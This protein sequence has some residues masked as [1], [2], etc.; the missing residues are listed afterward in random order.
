MKRF[1]GDSLGS[2]PGMVSTALRPK[3]T[4]TCKERAS[5]TANSGQTPQVSE[6]VLAY[7]R[8]LE[9][10]SSRSRTPSRRLARRVRHLPRCPAT[11]PHCRECRSKKF[12]SDYADAHKARSC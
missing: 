6:S 10:R 9:Q 12:L 7:S 2:G 3:N 5:A 8:L 4:S 1:S 11:R